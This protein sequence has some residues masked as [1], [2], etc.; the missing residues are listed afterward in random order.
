MHR[1]CQSGYHCHSHSS[2]K[3]NVTSKRS[4]SGRIPDAAVTV[5]TRPA[6]SS[7]RY[8]LFFSDCYFCIKYKVG[9]IHLALGTCH[10]TVEGDSKRWR[11]GTLLPPPSALVSRTRQKPSPLRRAHYEQPFRFADTAEQ[12]S[13]P[14]HGC[15]SPRRRSVF[16]NSEPFQ[17]P[18][19]PDRSRV[20]F[21]LTPAS[22]A[23]LP[24]PIF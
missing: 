15:V 6:C 20:P 21:L 16:E 10:L 2:Y 8:V 1:Q 19:I 24:V 5:T 12:G 7:V 18:P 14:A 22:S 11:F 4:T 3:F 17:P 13:L 23:V 9:G